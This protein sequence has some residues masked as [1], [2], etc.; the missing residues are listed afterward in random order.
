M[1]ETPCS[2]GSVAE[3][4]DTWQLVEEKCCPTC[5]GPKGHGLGLEAG[6]ERRPAAIG[7]PLVLYDV[8]LAVRASGGAADRWL[9]R[10]V[11]G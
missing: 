5:S 4:Y 11:S 1:T 10:W 3:A 6:Q 2:R 9:R 8:P 7:L